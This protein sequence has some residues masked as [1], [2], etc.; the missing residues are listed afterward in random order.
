MKSKWTPTIIVTTLSLIIWAVA[1]IHGYAIATIWI[2]AV[3]LGASWPRETKA[4]RF[5]TCWA[6][7]RRTDS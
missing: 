1:M 2:P 3:A 6:R 4:Q 5:A 7:L